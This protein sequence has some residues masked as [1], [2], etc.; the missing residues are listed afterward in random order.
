MRGRWIGWNWEGRI[1]PACH[2]NRDALWHVTVGPYGDLEQILKNLR[3]PALAIRDLPSSELE[4]GFQ[5]TLA[6]S[7]STLL[8]ET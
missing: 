3:R 1:W 5:P 2:F 4:A 7:L 8:R 6:N